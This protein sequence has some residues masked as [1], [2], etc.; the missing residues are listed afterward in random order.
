MADRPYSWVNLLGPFEHNGDI[1]IFKGKEVEV[2]ASP[3]LNVP[4]VSK[5]DSKTGPKEQISPKLQE[6]RG[7]IGQSV[8]DQRFTE[9]RISVEIEFAT[10][11]SSSVAEIILQ[12][13]PN[14]ED[15]LTVG[16]G[17]DLGG[18]FSLR[19]WT[20]DPAAPGRPPKAWRYLRSGGDR[21][22][23]RPKERY[24][25]DVVVRGSVLTLSV[26]GVEVGTGNLPFQLPGHQVGIFCIGISDIHFRRFHVDST[27]P[28]AFVVMQ[29]NTSE[30]EE[31]YQDVIRPVCESMGL[32]PFRAS[33][34]YSPGLVVADI[35][36]QIA[37]SRVI[38]A[39]ITP[40]NANVYYEV[41]YADALGK[42]VILIA[43]KTVQELPFDVRPY[44]TIFYENSIGGKNKVEETLR[45]YLT[46]IVG[47]R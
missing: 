33:D 32:K 29:F 27:L 16:M 22:N 47:Q 2:L 26:N 37:E 44:R 18:L 15:M 28:Q 14:T 8:C 30:Y 9:G 23:L 46:T 31:L 11:D 45:R 39:E 12:Y 38:I 6:K 43:D 21:S 24:Q 36:R 41:G 3:E 34:T 42:P 5:K 4:P 10:V 20:G 13:D 17:G 35:A 7:L 1:I 19:H 40:V 25:V